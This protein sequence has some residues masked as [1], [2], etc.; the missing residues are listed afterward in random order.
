MKQGSAQDLDLAEL[1][2]RSQVLTTPCGNGEMVWRVWGTGPTV[3]LLHGAY[4]SWMHWARNI[5]GLTEGHTIVAP[6][7][8]GLGE[9]DMPPE[10]DNGASI[11]RV[12]AEGLD[13]VLSPSGT[14]DLVGFSFGG[15]LGSRLAVLHAERVRSLVV[16]GTG[17]FGGRPAVKLEAWRHVTDDAARAA[18]HRR[19]LEALMF[20]DP[21]SADDVAVRIQSSNAEH[22]R[23][24]NR[25]IVWPTDYQS[26][27]QELEPPLTAIYGERDAMLHPSADTRR[28]QLRALK[29]DADLRIVPGAGH[30]AQYETPAAFNSTL[31]EVLARER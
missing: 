24:N 8:P 20:A 22:S 6:D 25:R 2:A 18:I 1:R 27:L 3:L 26:V 11:V 9:S 21:D 14:Y 10:P 17:G 12:V 5:D 13:L 30:W 23:L 29:P 19:N 7:L 15:T 4:G 16:V 31:L 28:Q